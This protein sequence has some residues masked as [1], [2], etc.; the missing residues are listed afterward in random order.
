MIEAEKAFAIMQVFGKPA[1]ATLGVKH[2]Q[3]GMKP[4]WPDSQQV[5]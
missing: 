2:V 3:R 5:G 4:D 1:G